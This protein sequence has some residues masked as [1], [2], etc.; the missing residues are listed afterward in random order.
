MKRK[1]LLLR[2]IF[3]VINYKIHKINYGAPFKHN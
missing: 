3:K 2:W 1:K